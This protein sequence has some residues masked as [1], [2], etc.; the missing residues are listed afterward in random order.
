MLFEVVGKAPRAVKRA[1]LPVAKQV[2]LGHQ[3]LLEQLDALAG[4]AAAPVIAIREVEG[5]D[6][7][8]CGG[9]A[10]VDQAVA[11]LVGRGDL[12]AATLTDVV[13]RLLVYLFGRRIVDDIA[14]VD[15]FILRAQP[16]LDPEGRDPHQLL[17][18]GAHRARDIHHV[19][20][21][22]VALGDHGLLPG[23]IAHIVADGH[24]DRVVGVVLAGGDL[25]AQ[26]LVVGALEV[27]QRVGASAADA[28]VL[29]LLADE[30]LLALGLNVGQLELLAEDRGELVERDIDLQ[31][32]LAGLGAG[33]ALAGL[34]LALADRVAHIAVALAHAAAL[35]G[36]VA[37]LRDVDLRHGDAHEALALAPDH[38]AV[39][40]ILAQIFFDLTAHD[41]PKAAE[42]AVHAFH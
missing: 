25:A 12:G 15:L 40:H 34:R 11:E 4:I 31:R 6:V 9:V 27:A 37:E 20:N 3:L 39:R 33:L 1:H 38:L 26:R 10:L 41:L 17:L 16:G 32:M 5:V 22:G 42:V 35:L 30:V 21:D 28:A 2:H 24:N 14:N 7:P 13:E 18:L 36:A 8:L 29:I 23:A 19:D